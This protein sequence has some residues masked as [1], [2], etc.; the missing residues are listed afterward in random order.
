MGLSLKS[1]EVKERKNVNQFKNYSVLTNLEKLDLL[2]SDSQRI[3]DYI[4]SYSRLQ[5]LSIYMPVGEIFLK[6]AHEAFGLY[7]DQLGSLRLL[8]KLNIAEVDLAFDPGQLLPLAQAIVRTCARLRSLQLPPVKHFSRKEAAHEYEEICSA[9]SHL[10]HLEKL[11]LPLTRPFYNW[12]GLHG[13]SKLARI[14][15]SCNEC[16]TI[17]FETTLVSYICDYNLAFAEIFVN[18]T[19]FLPRIWDD[20]RCLFNLYHKLNVTLSTRYYR[21]ACS[22]API[23]VLLSHPTILQASE[24][25]PSPGETCLDILTTVCG[26]KRFS[27]EP[28]DQV[29][30]LEKRFQERLKEAGRTISM[31][32][33]KRALRF[34]IEKRSVLSHNAI[35]AAFA[36][37]GVSDEERFKWYNMDELFLPNMLKIISNI[38]EEPDL[39]RD[40]RLA[41]LF[42]L[43]PSRGTLF[44][45]VMANVARR[46]LNGPL[47]VRSSWCILLVL[48]LLLLQ[49]VFDSLLPNFVRIAPRGSISELL[50]RLGS[51]EGILSV[52]E[53]APFRAALAV[54]VPEPEGFSY[55]LR[56]LQTSEDQFF[57]F[58]ALLP[59][60]VAR[61]IELPACCI[62]SPSALKVALER[63]MMLSHARIIDALTT[64][65]KAISDELW[66][67]YT[68]TCFPAAAART[69]GLKIAVERGLVDI[70]EKFLAAGVDV[71]GVDEQ[72]N[73]VLHFLPWQFRPGLTQ[74]L[75]SHGAKVDQTNTEGLTPLVSLVKTGQGHSRFACELLE[76]GAD[77]LAQVHD[78]ANIFTVGSSLAWTS[79]L[80]DFRVPEIPVDFIRTGSPNGGHLIAHFVDKNQEESLISLFENLPSQDWDLFGE[81]ELLDKLLSS[82][83]QLS[84]SVVKYVCSGLAGHDYAQ[85]ALPIIADRFSD[86]CAVSTSHARALIGIVKDVNRVGKSG[87]TPLLQACAARRLPLILPLLEQGADPCFADPRGDTSL[88][89]LVERAGIHPGLSEAAETLVAAVVAPRKS[90]FLEAKGRTER[91]ALIACIDLEKIDVLQT[92]LRATEWTFRS[93]WLA[94]ALAASVSRPRV[95]GVFLEHLKQI[96]S[97]EEFES[98]MRLVLNEEEAHN[99]LEKACAMEAVDSIRK[100]LSVAHSAYGGNLLATAQRLS[101]ERSPAPQTIRTPILFRHR[102]K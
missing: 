46:A 88:T 53:H 7:S 20:L 61:R 8:R 60:N 99:L 31:Q 35:L 70:V 34:T 77:L 89:L 65:E 14:Y 45:Q 26:D 69:P 18:Q 94:G 30:L 92:I 91:T 1:F 67:H 57:R 83:P 6:F 71:N 64:A 76:H 74:L 11:K 78:K 27:Q 44:S 40:E 13:A 101:A 48:F 19:P 12:S 21:A 63:G 98:T 32:F 49:A 3:F 73:S 51:M 80:K 50:A 90:S 23:S 100:I 38:L 72:G 25:V 16:D 86:E 93:P 47:R 79:A 28:F 62:R 87:R 2:F 96:M 24:S 15:F 58:A 10:K 54:D 59:E 22:S 41:N 95:L 82:S 55:M 9:V 75:F 39:R 36:D 97:F 81:P 17:P 52:L 29:V 37:V 42:G 56:T 4:P 43:G 102:L 33:V 66:C 85:A 68:N 84:T 5:Q